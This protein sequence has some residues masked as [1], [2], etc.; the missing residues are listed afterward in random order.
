MYFVSYS[1][2]Y[3][4]VHQNA[5]EVIFQ[6]I[7][8][9]KLS[10]DDKLKLERHFSSSEIF[11]AAKMMSKNKTPGIYGFPIELYIMF[12]E[13]IQDL[14]LDSYNYSLRKGQLSTSQRNGIISLFLKKDKDPLNPKS[15]RPISLLTVDYKI[16]AK[17]IIATR[18]KT[19]NHNIID[20]DQSGFMKGRPIGH[21][22]RQLLDV[23]EYT[24][25][26]S[27]SGAAAG[28]VGY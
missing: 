7:N 24:D 15:Y 20:E 4:S 19:V 17:A 26:E 10:C 1:N 2:L 11:A 27:I 16:L 25:F 22:I 9:P 18:I 14:L 3:S 8:I 5:D 23:I 12:W 21:N 28:P 13:D 6:E